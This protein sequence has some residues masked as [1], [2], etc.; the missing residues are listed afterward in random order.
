[1]Q[2][3]IGIISSGI[4]PPTPHP[5]LLFTHTLSY[6]ILPYFALSNLTLPYLI[7]FYLTLSYLMNRHASDDDNINELLDA[8]GVKSRGDRNKI[9]KSI[10]SM[11]SVE[12]RPVASTEVD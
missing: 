9:M 12:T 11:R 10:E 2:D 8:C 6:L 5:S 4:Y 3:I 1:M 7:L